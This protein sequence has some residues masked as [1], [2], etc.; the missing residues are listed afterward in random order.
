MPA[1][2]YETLKA[3]V[4]GLE[5]DLK[6]AAADNKR[7]RAE[8]VL[9]QQERDEAY[10]DRARL[11]RELEKAGLVLAEAATNSEAYRTGLVKCVQ[12]LIT[13]HQTADIGYVLKVQTVNLCEELLALLPEN[14]R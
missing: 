4:A 12:F 3:R 2:S 1:P 10:S 6:E 8:L 11:E 9:V 13:L 7:V 5:H 14:D